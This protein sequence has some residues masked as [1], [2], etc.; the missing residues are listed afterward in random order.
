MTRL[1]AIHQPNF[2][3]WLGY[4]DKIIRSDVFIFL[5]DV[6]YPKTGG[7]WCNRVKVLV[8]GEPR[9]LSA[10]INRSYHG[11]RKINEMSFVSTPHWRTKIR[12]TLEL[13]YCKHPFFGITMDIIL[14]LLTNTESN[15][16][17]FNIHAVTALC[18]SLGIDTSGLR[19]SSDYPSSGSSTQL[20]CTLTET[21]GCDTY[22]C[23]GGAAGYQD[24]Q[25]FSARGLGLVY[26]SYSQPVYSQHEHPLFSPGLSIID[27]LM[28]LGPSGVLELLSPAD[29]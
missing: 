13:Q 2:F 6:A 21:L 8:S 7:A 18:V 5:D 3:P 9:W 22:L 29:S 4:F 27:A 24:D 26:Q 11:S 10:P 25:A 1:A 15:I 23:G 16:A 12:K 14:P 20:L 17:K 28:N 19:R